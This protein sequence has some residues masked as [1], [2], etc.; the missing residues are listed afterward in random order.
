MTP[1]GGAA[2]SVRQM[3]SRRECDA[4]VFAYPLLVASRA[5]NRVNRLFIA[6]GA[7]GTFRICGWLD[8]S[9]E[10]VVLALPEACGRYLVLWLRD[11]WNA[12]FASVGTRTTGC[13]AQAYAVLGPGRHGER[14][15]S[16]L[17][18]IAAPTRLVRV[19]GCVEATDAADARSL[20][21]RTAPLSRWSG[22]PDGAP[23]TVREA[24]PRPGA[25]PVA[26]V[27]RLD[28]GGFFAEAVRLSAANPPEPGDRPALDALVRDVAC[29]SRAALEHGARR[30]REAIRAAARAPGGELVGGWRVSYEPGRYGTD[31][32]R[33]AAAVRSGLEAG[34]ATDHLPAVLDTDADG[35]P[36]TGR[37][38][39][40]LRFPADAPPPVNAFWSLTTGAGW[41]GDL[42]GLKLD[43]DGSLPIHVQHSAPE[44]VRGA[45]WLPAPPD[46]F[47]VVLRL[48]WPG[49]DALQGRW[50]PPA[51]T[52]VA[53][54]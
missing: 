14:I 15:R 13:R 39:Y 52:R 51:M 7:P 1:A 53:A 45:N 4:Y 34:P 5:V 33:R 43:A 11:A 8:L 54:G 44:D 29:A 9:G 27:E 3:D 41:I 18:R 48:Y 47:S 22:P 19:T 30:G 25:D 46:R 10:P 20:G 40:V 6:P 17:G 2:E 28:A 37:D 31:Y 21:I 38:R 50:T 42:H 26:G 32:L 36:L 12:A 49:E 16:P 35:R 23:A 24:P